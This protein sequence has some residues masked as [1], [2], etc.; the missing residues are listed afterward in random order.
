MLLPAFMTKIGQMLSAKVAWKACTTRLSLS[1]YASIATTARNICA[2]FS[3]P[4]S[5]NTLSSSSLI[6]DPSRFFVRVRLFW[7][8]PEDTLLAGLQHFFNA[9]EMSDFEPL[10]GRIGL[11]ISKR[12]K[13]TYDSSPCVPVYQIC[14]SLRCHYRFFWWPQPVQSRS[15]FCLSSS[16]WCWS[17]LHFRRLSP[18][19]SSPCCL[20]WCFSLSW[21]WSSCTW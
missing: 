21:S 4:D 6:V 20:P 13:S 12:W 2:N 16:C 3:A 8:S 9:V 5:G 15:S 10:L 14:S 17:S 19:C 18:C 1:E 11:K 7:H